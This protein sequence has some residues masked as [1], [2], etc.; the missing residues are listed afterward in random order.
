[1]KEPLSR[2]GIR[3]LVQEILVQESRGGFSRKT[4]AGGL[5]YL[6]QYDAT[7]VAVSLYD[8][9]GED[10]IG[11]MDARQYSMRRLRPDAGCDQDIV[12]LGGGPD[13]TIFGVYDSRIADPSN[14][15]KG[16]GKLMYEICIYEI[17]SRHGGFFF[18][19][20][21]CTIGTT[22]GDAM[23]VWDSL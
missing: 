21:S 14:R 17:F 15:G 18:V 8:E 5:M 13:S 22:T 16:Y 11:M 4:T 19:P 9:T 20:M 12:R 7:A 10:I 2:A 23:R 6:A 1:M 3:E